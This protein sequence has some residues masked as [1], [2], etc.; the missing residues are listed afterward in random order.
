LTTSVD[1]VDRA[2]SR[3]AQAGGAR[4]LQSRA[5]LTS[6]RS[7]SSRAWTDADAR[8]GQLLHRRPLRAL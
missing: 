8:T 3:P 2:A 5:V 4:L 1:V 7:S 6:W